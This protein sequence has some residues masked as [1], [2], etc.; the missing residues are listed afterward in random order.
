MSSILQS[1]STN[2]INIQ[3]EPTEALKAV[4][5]DLDDI[6]M[7]EDQA[8]QSKEAER[9]AYNQLFTTNNGS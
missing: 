8:A 2:Q 5:I 9:A 7:D 3:A 4:Q 6:S 1:N